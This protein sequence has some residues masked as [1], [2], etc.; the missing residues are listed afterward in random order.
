MYKVDISKKNVLHWNKIRGHFILT[1]VWFLYSKHLKWP[2]AHVSNFFPIFNKP[3]NEILLFW[4]YIFRYNMYFVYTCIIFFFNPCDKTLF[5]H[6][7]IVSSDEICLYFM[8]TLHFSFTLVV[9]QYLVMI[10][11][12]PPFWCNYLQARSFLREED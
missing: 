2:H 8:P 12:G 10:E 9:R 4:R 3:G 5:Y 11:T 6:V 1:T 7:N